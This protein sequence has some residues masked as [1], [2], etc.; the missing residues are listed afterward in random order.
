MRRAVLVACLAAVAS[1]AV[2]CTAIVGFPAVPAAPDAGGEGTRTS[3]SA[4]GESS[5]S[6]RASTTTRATTSTTLGS[7]AGSCKGS[8][9]ILF[10]SAT[11]ATGLSVSSLSW[12]HTV[13]HADDRAL[14]VIVSARDP[15][16]PT[17]TGVTYGPTALTH[18]RSLAPGGGNLDL[19]IWM[20]AAP[21][22]G[23]AAVAFTLSGQ[24]TGVSGA[25]LSYTGVAQEGTVD[26]S[27][28]DTEMSGAPSLRWS[29]GASATRA[30]A[31]ATTQAGGIQATLGAN[32]TS[33]YDVS[34]MGPWETQS[35][36]DQSSITASTR[37]LAFNW[38]TTNPDPWITMGFSFVPACP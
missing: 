16:L 29:A 30:L 8:S 35:G 2:A 27:A 34:D 28:D 31:V 3:A 7:S 20:L 11:Q 12:S 5:G 25:A 4:S 37:N 36:V 23:T 24:A 15:S 10:D 19:E 21:P 32:Q 6:S 17:V 14:F 26:E 18:V 38:T 33:R 22:S 1:A 13:G 9:P